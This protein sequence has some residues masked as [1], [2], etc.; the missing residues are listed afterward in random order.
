M[1]IL[2]LLTILFP[3][4]VQ[5]FISSFKPEL[6]SSLEY[7]EGERLVIETINR[8]TKQIV[9][10]FQA[11]PTELILYSSKSYIRKPDLNKKEVKKLLTDSIVNFHI[12]LI[13]LGKEKIRLESITK[14]DSDL[15]KEAQGLEWLRV[16]IE[17]LKKGIQHCL[18][19]DDLAYKEILFSKERKEGQELRL[20]ILSLDFKIVFLRDSRLEVTCWNYKDTVDKSLETTPAFKGY[21]YHQKNQVFDLFIPLIKQMSQAAT[22]FNKL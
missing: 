20:Q 10:N 19:N 14:V 16:S 9:T 18:D 15:A 4:S 21:F 6:N 11:Q 13:E 8:H 7:L 12:Y 3:E 5:G 22:R 2:R 1:N 17:V